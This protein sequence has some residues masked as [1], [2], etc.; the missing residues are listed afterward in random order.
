MFQ[1]LQG[2]HDDVG[3]YMA[4]IF[5]SPDVVSYAASDV[6]ESM[7]A[8]DLPLLPLSLQDNMPM[9]VVVS[10]MYSSAAAKG[11]VLAMHR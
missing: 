11:N 8:S 2:K 6:D 5:F 3:Y 9:M 10:Q 7:L 1:S 4:E